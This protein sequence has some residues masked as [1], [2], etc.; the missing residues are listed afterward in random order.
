MIRVATWNIGEDEIHE[1]NIVNLDSYSYI[2]DM[3]THHKIDIICLQESI[4]SS[5]IIE[6]ISNYIKNNTK[7][8][9]TSEFELSESH[10]NTDSMMGVTICSKLPINKTKKIMFDNPNL[11]FKKDE[12]KTYISHNKGFVVSY[13]DSIPLIISN[14]HCMPFHIFKK[15]PTDYQYIFKNMEDKM[16]NIFEENFIFTGDMNYENI[17][18]L[19]PNIASLTNQLDFEKTY[20]DIQIDHILVSKKIKVINYEV[21]ATRFDHNLC[22]CDLD[23]N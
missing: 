11:I 4:T 19:F 15:K 2:K 6:P 5:N 12:I 3:I 9:Y 1:K 14:G 10:I 22:I 8:K 20:K 18:E 16:L 13:I 23:V 17:N 21:V 7:L